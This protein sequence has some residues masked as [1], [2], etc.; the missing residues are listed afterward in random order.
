MRLIIFFHFDQS[1]IINISFKSTLNYFYGFQQKFIV[2]Q[3]AFSHLQLKGAIF[4]KV[5]I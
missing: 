5:I 3:I 1:I 2:L 4:K